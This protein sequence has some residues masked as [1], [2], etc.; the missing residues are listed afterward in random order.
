MQS[1]QPPVVVLGAAAPIVVSAVALVADINNATRATMTPAIRTPVRLCTQL[2]F[3]R[4]RYTAS[5][6]R[7]FDQRWF[8]AETTP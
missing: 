5:V 4:I 2:S 7:F 3:T 8:V 1:E 6:R